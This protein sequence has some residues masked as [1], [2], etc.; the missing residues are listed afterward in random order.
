MSFRDDV[1]A[2]LSAS[3]RR[4]SS[5]Y[6]YD[7]R[8]SELFDQICELDAYYV[9]RT[10][11]A[12]LNAVAQEMATAIGPKAVLIEFGSGSAQKTEILLSHL[13]AP[14]A[15]VPIDISKSALDDSASRMAAAFPA[16][17]VAT[18]HADFTGQIQ[19][20]AIPGKRVVYYPGST[21]GNFVPA[22]VDRFLQRV[23]ALVAEDGS[24]LIG[25][26]L[27]KSPSVLHRAYNDELGVTAAFNKNLL[28]RMA[29]ELDAQ[30][31]VDAF[32]HYAFFNPIEG[33]IEMHLIATRPTQV[34]IDQQAF[35]FAAGEG[36]L[37]EYSYK[38]S[39]QQFEAVARKNSFAVDHFWTDPAGFFGVWLLSA[40]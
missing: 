21:I 17:E 20:P 10:E 15:W 4:I 27:K 14:R 16:L 26:D 12:L 22:E 13:E 3:P 18:V 2:G 35:S 19:L 8:G 32:E 25:V 33:R 6:F 9:T 29:Q 5:K 23:R 38:Y 1:I 36:I 24:L 37:T 31:D 11:V 28:R 40:R 39:R 34:V 7:R 30:V